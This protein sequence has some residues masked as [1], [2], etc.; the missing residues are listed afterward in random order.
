MAGE[1]RRKKNLK[2]KKIGV[3]G[4][5]PRKGKTF[6]LC[7]YLIFNNY[8]LNGAGLGMCSVQ[9]EGRTTE[10]KPQLSMGRGG[11]TGRDGVGA[12]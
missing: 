9:S 10:T 6:I 11:R 8:L 5:F 3:A 2:K 4:K 1:K 12:M 7:M